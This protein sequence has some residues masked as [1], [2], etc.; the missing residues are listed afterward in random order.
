MVRFNIQKKDLFAIF[1][2]LIITFAFFT[3]LFYPHL[4]LFITPEYNGS[5]TTNFNIPVKLILSQSLKSNTYPLWEK[6]IATGFPLLAESQIGYFYIPNYLLFK[7]LNFPIAFNIGYILSFFM[8]FSGMY[9]LMRYKKFEVMISLFCGFVFGF[10][11][12]FVGHMN[13]YNMLQAASLFPWLILIF[14]YVKKRGDILSVIVFSFILSQQVFAG[15]AQ[16][17]FITLFTVFSLYFFELLLPLKTIKT[18]FPSIYV[19]LYC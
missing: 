12:F 18:R 5:D 6:T 17:T 4:S 7:Y 3:R 1:I 9:A 15:Y 13:H 10:S 2:V 19:L 14:E 11:G 8:T 16:I